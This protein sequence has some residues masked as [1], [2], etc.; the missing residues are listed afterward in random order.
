MNIRLSAPLTKDSIVDGKGLRTVVWTQGCL[1]NCKG[2]HNPKTHDLNGGFLVDVEKI[3]DEL[4]NVKMQQGITLSGGEP[5]LQPKECSEIAK[6]AKSLGMDVWCFT[7][8]LYEDLKK[9]SER[10][11]LLK[12]I[13]VLVDGPFILEEK[14]YDL[15]FKGSRNQRIIQLENGELKEIIG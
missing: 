10:C 14:S 7:G 11:E 2:C 6:Y 9:D 1:H 3:K 15:V 5:F 8:F 4:K 12:Y 13:D